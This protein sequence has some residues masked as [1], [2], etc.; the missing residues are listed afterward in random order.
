M[1]PLPF[2]DLQSQYQALQPGIQTRINKV[3]E[4]GKYINGPEVR[5]LEE[6]LADHVGVKHAIGCANGTDALQLALL[7]LGV[8]PGDAVF[9]TTFTFFATAEVIALC[10]ARP[11]FVD[12]EADTYNMSALDLEARIGELAA[13]GELTAKAIIAV[14]LFGLPADYPAIEKIAR[15]HKL[16]LIEDAAQAFG[17]KI[18]MKRA[19]GFGDLATT[20]F[21]PA[22]PLGCYGDGG[23]LFTNDDDQAQLLRSLRVHGQG[24]DKYDNVRIGVN[25]RLDTIQAAI[26]LEKLAVNEE[27]RE[28]KESVA[29]SYGRLL[30]AAVS[31]PVVP[32]G[33]SSAWA[34]YTVRVAD[35]ESVVNCLQ[36]AGVPAMVYYARCMH[37][38]TAFAGMADGSTSYP[39]AEAAS[40]QVLSLPMHAY[41]SGCE[42]EKVA[43]AVAGA[44]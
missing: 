28:R 38:Q 44:H 18:G 22:K 4:H 10:G 19:G 43:S 37:Q 29:E 34:Q 42:V 35:R 24:E 8:G 3:L 14:D 16:A 1:K 23:A 11:V 5:E 20:S 26:L 13:E 15:D 17:G 39:V 36:E 25:S 41:L 12:I 9:T 27:E 31:R 2:I 33:Y 6:K 32:A 40:K 21:F 30:P 7:A